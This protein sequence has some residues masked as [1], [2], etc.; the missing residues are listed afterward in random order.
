MGFVLAPLEEGEVI[1]PERLQRLSREE[2]EGIERK[3]EELQGELQ[4]TVF[5]NRST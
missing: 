2:R 3:I 5:A 1:S 4:Q